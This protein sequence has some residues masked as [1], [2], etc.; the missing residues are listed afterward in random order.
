M[1]KFLEY[2]KQQKIKFNDF[3]PEDAIE[4]YLP[5]IYQQLC[6]SIIIPYLKD[7]LGGGLEEIAEAWY[8]DIESL[9]DF[10]PLSRYDLEVKEYDNHAVIQYDLPN[11]YDNIYYYE[12]F[13]DDLSKKYGYNKDWLKQQISDSYY[14]DM[15]NDQI[16]NE[17]T[18][19]DGMVYNDDPCIV[20]DVNLEY[21]YWDFSFLERLQN[22]I[23]DAFVESSKNWIDED[24]ELK[25][26]DDVYSFINDNIDDGRDLINYVL[27]DIT[28][29]P[30]EYLKFDEEYLNK[31]ASKMQYSFDYID[32]FVFSYNC[33]EY[34]I[35]EL[36]EAWEDYQM[37]QYDKLPDWEE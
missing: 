15:L 4:Y 21:V 36:E 1:R 13:I 25:S 33:L 22:T 2:V 9:G 5:E 26:A 17:M 10:Y 12:S 20:N 30:Y 18:Y 14:Y 6:D 35:S 7:E 28:E 19:L 16:N 34:K 32:S 31:N 27:G 29:I 24:T 8:M 37:E 23:I 11:P 3:L